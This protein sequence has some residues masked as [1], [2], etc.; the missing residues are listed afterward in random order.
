MET[1]LGRTGM[2][3]RGRLK[4]ARKKPSAFGISQDLADALWIIHSVK[5]ANR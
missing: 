1:T 3:V 2:A 5:A 4:S